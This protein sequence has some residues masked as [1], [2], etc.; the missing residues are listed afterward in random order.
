[1]IIITIIMIVLNFL[2]DWWLVGFSVAAL[3]VVVVVYANNDDEDDNRLYEVDDDADD[4][5]KR[6]RKNARAEFFT[7]R[8]AVAFL[9]FSRSSHHTHAHYKIISSV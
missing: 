8:Q 2:R 1:M 7:H 5:I 6:K 4:D 3:L 9:F